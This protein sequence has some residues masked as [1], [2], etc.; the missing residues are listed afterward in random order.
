MC[1]SRRCGSWP[2]AV[3]L[4]K[5]FQRASLSCSGLLLADLSRFGRRLLGSGR[6]RF[7]RHRFQAAL[8]ADLAAYRTLLL[9]ESQNLGR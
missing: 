4:L 2:E 9:E 5:L 1:G 7:G 8:P 6:P 3:D